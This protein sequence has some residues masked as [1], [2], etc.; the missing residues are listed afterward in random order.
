MTRIDRLAPIAAA[1]ALT[2]LAPL[3]A[4]TVNRSVVQVPQ[5]PAP[6]TITPATPGRGAPSPTGLTSPFPAGLPSPSPF[7]AGLPP[8]ARPTLTPPT[9]TTATP[10]APVTPPLDGTVLMPST[11]IGSTG[12][13]NNGANTGANGSAGAAGTAVMGAGGGASTPRAAPSGAG[14]YTA[15]QLAESFQRADANRDGDLTRN[16]FQHLTIAPAQFDEMDRNRDG[17]ISRSEY[18]DGSR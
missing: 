9:A 17:L 5:R 15:L 18:D 4:Q 1:F 7:P 2:A 3:H 6:A 8:V 13:V 12:F 14:P 10:T 16:E 11:A